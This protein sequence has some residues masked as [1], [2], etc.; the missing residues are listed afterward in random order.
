MPRRLDDA[1]APTYH[2]TSDAWFSACRNRGTDSELTPP[3]WTLI[4]RITLML[5]TARP[6]W[7]R[8]VKKTIPTLSPHETTQKVM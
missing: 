4:A 3:R 8:R 5:E 1:N 7:E 2:F 6:V